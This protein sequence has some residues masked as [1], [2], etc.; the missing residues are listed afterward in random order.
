MRTLV[1]AAIVAAG[2]LTALVQPASAAC[3]PGYHKVKIQGNSICALKT[4]NLPLKAK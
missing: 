4:P 1:I 2:S 3:A